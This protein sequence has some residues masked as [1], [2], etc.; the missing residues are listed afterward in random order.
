MPADT[1]A[2][3]DE[4]PLEAGLYWFYGVVCESAVKG[5][6][7][8][9]RLVDVYRIGPKDPPGPPKQWWRYHT[10]G[11]NLF[12]HDPAGLRSVGKWQKAVP[13]DLPPDWKPTPTEKSHGD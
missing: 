10:T 4:I 2:W 8:K 9:L 5:T 11:V 13:P 7:P 12:P 1:S 3:S 6:E